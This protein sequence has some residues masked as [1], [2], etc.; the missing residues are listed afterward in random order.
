MEF[1]VRT[2]NNNKRGNS[3]AV[4]SKTACR[5]TLKL[6][7]RLKHTKCKFC[8]LEVKRETFWVERYVFV[9]WL[10]M[11]YVKAIL[12]MVF[13][14]LKID[15]STAVQTKVVNGTVLKRSFNA[16]QLWCLVQELKLDRSWRISNRS[17]ACVVDEVITTMQTCR[18]LRDNISVNI[19]P[20]SIILEDL[21]RS[22]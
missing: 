20:K 15:I 14:S 18:T 7:R 22:W 1:A 9:F 8:E 6:C 21:E 12:T 11:L 2:M 10:C 4:N 19:P 13:Q 3:E 5:N 16:L 17:D